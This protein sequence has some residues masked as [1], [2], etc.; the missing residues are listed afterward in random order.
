MTAATSGQ[1]I[2]FQDR[3]RQFVEYSRQY[4][5]RKIP[6][7]I[8]VRMVCVMGSVRIVHGRWR[9]VPDVASPSMRWWPIHQAGRITITGGITGDPLLHALMVTFW[10]MIWLA[11]L[12]EP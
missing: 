10:R 9:H 11:D 4:Q 5:E 12:L 8:P 7:A 2:T 1:T 3:Q 6:M